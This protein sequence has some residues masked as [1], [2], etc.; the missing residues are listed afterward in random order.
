MNLKK[1]SVILVA[2]I[3]IIFTIGIAIRNQ[4]DASEDYGAIFTNDENVVMTQWITITID[5]N[6]VTVDTYAQNNWYDIRQLTT[7]R[8]LTI[9]AG[10]FSGCTVTVNGVPIE[11]NGTVTLRL[12]R[13]NAL[14]GIEISITNTETQNET[15]NYIR[16]LPMIYS[17]ATIL[18]NE[19]DKGFYYFN[20]DNYIFKADTKG[21]V[22]FYK[23]LDGTTLSGYDFKRTEVDGKVYYSYLAAYEPADNAALEGVGYLRCYAVVMDENYNEIDR[24]WCLTESDGKTTVLENH[25]FTILGEKH[26]LLS[27]YVGKRVTNIPATVPHSNLGARVVADV[28]QEIKDGQVI[29][30][31]DS[32]EHPELYALSVESNDFYNKTVQWADYAHFNGI[33]V[34]PRDNN[35]VCS[36]RNLNSILK[37]DRTTGEIIWVLGGSGDQFGLTEEQLF[38]RQHDIRITEDGAYTLFN[39]GNMDT[40]MQNGATSVMKFYLDEEKMTVEKFENYRMEESFS[41]AMGSAQELEPGQYVISWGQSITKNAV[42]SE[43]DFHENKVMF[44]FCYPG[45]SRNYR[46]YKDIA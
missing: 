11:S 12:E 35:F 13:L 6:P 31:W 4:S 37:L 38:S 16:T 24:V 34:D 18:S 19:P 46:V 23:Q 43:I 28:I 7:E 44:E 33:T 20:L 21:N 42:F 17:S 27:A 30:E 8:D 32:T 45:T 9:T 36:F 10:E 2:A 15:K 14:E 26:Y 25:Q 40:N 3:L 5:G 1:I 39:N 29:W 22:V 41:G